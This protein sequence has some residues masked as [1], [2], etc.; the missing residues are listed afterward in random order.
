MKK[1]ILI[2]L[3]ALI[4]N[5]YAQTVLPKDSA[6]VNALF[7]KT[8]QC[9][10]YSQ[11]RQLYL[12][13]IL[14]INHGYAWA[15]QQKAMPLFKQRKYSLA[16]PFLDSAVRYQKNVEWLEYRGFMR[17]IFIKDYQGA[18][19]DFEQCRPLNRVG[20][21][22]DHS[23]DFYEG[24]SF[25]M[26]NR[27]PEAEKLIARSIADGEKRSSEAHF[28]EYFYLGIVR[29]EL[30]KTDEA[31]ASLNLALK[32]YPCFSDAFFYLA[33]CKQKKND[34]T[35]AAELYKKGYACKK[36][37]Y[38][39]NEDNVIYEWYPYQVREEEYRAKLRLSN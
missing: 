33:L 35:S 16:I 27:F 2:V 1:T 11:E 13:T 21:V 19:N 39:I 8:F 6:R 22:M 26:L 36:Q 3:V 9:D 10:L 15:W 17:C 38:T 12:D 29:M 28:L 14:S 37:G 5:T 25:L 31:I 34:Y 23:Y 7:R 4:S 24:L 32:Y 20:F 30:N 18:I